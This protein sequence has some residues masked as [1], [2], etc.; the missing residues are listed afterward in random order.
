M[1]R[2][3]PHGDDAHLCAHCEIAIE[4]AEGETHHA[5]RSVHQLAQ[6]VVHRQVIGLVRGQ[7]EQAHDLLLGGSGQHTGPRPDDGLNALDRHVLGHTELHLGHP[8]HA[9]VVADV[10][11]GQQQRA[12]DDHQPGPVF[13]V[14][15]GVDRCRELLHVGTV[16]QIVREYHCAAVCAEEERGRHVDTSFRLCSFASCAAPTTRGTAAGWGTKVGQFWL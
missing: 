14:Q 16:A 5:V 3:A 1:A 2:V 12:R 13:E 15:H 7:I 9:A 10:V 6:G 4:R 11:L 8:G